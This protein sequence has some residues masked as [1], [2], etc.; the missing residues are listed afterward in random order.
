MGIFGVSKYI[1]VPL[2]AVLVWVVVVRGS[3]K[4]V[5][6]ILILFSLIYFAYPVS[7]F[8]AHPDWHLALHDTFV[9]Q[10]SATIRTI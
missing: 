10:W 1:C 8:L 4:P 9:P 5:E 7:A 3:Y 2:G 6:R